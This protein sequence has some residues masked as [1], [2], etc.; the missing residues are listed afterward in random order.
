MDIAEAF[1][2]YAD[3]AGNVSPLYERL[4]QGVTD[5]SALLDI[6]AEASAD[7]PPPQ[8]LLGAVHMLLLRGYDHP[9]ANFY[10]TCTETPAN[11][12]SF[13]HFRDFCLANENKLREIVASRRVQ[14]N[15]I[16]RSATRYRFGRLTV[17]S[18][19]FTVILRRQ[20]PFRDSIP[21][22]YAA[23]DRSNRTGTPN[24]AARGGGGANGSRH[25]PR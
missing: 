23:M 4:A 18:G 21:M 22:N 13:P 25:Q 11:G 17:K 7:Q 19:Y 5:D 8:L 6:A 15:E 14:T 24:G 12:D 16:G 2:W 1:E 3:W 9:V 20:I 10:P